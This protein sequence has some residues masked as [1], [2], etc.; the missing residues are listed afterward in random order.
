[1][2]PTPE[3]WRAFFPAGAALAGVGAAAWALRLWGVGPPI[4]P[5]EHGALM[6]FGVLGAFVQGFLLTAYPRQNQASPPTRARIGL[7]WLLHVIAA[8]STLLGGGLSQGVRAILLASPW[9]VTLA[10][11]LPIARVSLARSWDGTTFAVPCA[12]AALSLSAMLFPS[13]GS[14]ALAGAV[15]GGLVVLALAILDR[16]LPFFCQRPVPG[17]TGRRLPGF[18]PLLVAL[19]AGRALLPI[20][21]DSAIGLAVLDVMLV[22]LVLRQ[23]RGWA[24]WPA[25]KVP[26]LGALYL[27]VAWMIVAWLLDALSVLGLVSAGSAP[28]HTLMLG[29]LGTLVVAIATRVAR[30]HSNLPIEAGLG[31]GV[32]LVLV[33]A[34]TVLRLR[35]ALLGGAASDF[36]MAALLFALAFGWWFML[37]GRP[38][39][40]ARHGAH[41]RP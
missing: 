13:Y 29:G 35:A 2:T 3:A 27:G 14:V 41:E 20:A 25:I 5:I 18:I 8:T 17:Y 4:S 37:V 32:A 7:V 21:G 34:A 11:A 40:L 28:L 10:W 24:P 15:H 31:G 16:V 1:M 33:Q 6:I 22:G 38:G 19:S 9:L 26:M 12:L 30:G 23:V 39:A 36:G